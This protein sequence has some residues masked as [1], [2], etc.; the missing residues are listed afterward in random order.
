MFREDTMCISRR[1]FLRTTAAVGGSVLALQRSAH[2]AGSD[3]L[4]V[5]LVGCGSRGAGAA[6]NAI[7]ADPGVRVVA[8]ADAFADRVQGTL[9]ALKDRHPDQVD[10]APE[11]C[12]V[13]FDAYKEV[14]ACE[15]DVVLLAAPPHFRPLH[16]A[17]AI[18]AGKHVFAEKPVG[19]DATGVRSVMATC[20]RAKQKNLSVVS[21]LCWRYDTVIRETIKRVHDGAIGDIVAVQ[22]TRNLGYLWERTRQPEWTEMEFQMRNWYYFTW[23]SGDHNVE[24]QIHGLDKCTWALRDRAPVKAWATS[25]RQVRVEP[26]FGDIYDHHAVVYE[27]D[28]GARM[29]ALARQQPNCYN[30]YS[31]MLMG[32]KGRCDLQKGRIE[33]ETNWAFGQQAGDLSGF[34]VKKARKGALRPMHQVEQDEMFAAI[35]AGKTINNGDYMCQSTLIAIMGRTAGYTGQQITWEQMQ[36]SQ[37]DLSPQRYAFD[38]PPPT[39]PGPDGNYLVAMPGVTK[40]V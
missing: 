7:N 23:L 38:A 39:L 16:L 26:K 21:G 29:Y 1:Q 4:R 32:T 2:A 8:L 22:S 31:E 10:V 11:R 25:G 28:D 12:F 20:E 5:G 6:S 36:Q 14:I 15:V 37:L 19:V 17:A 30:D 40:F 18:E 34:G 27:Y 35:R 24:Q 13:G 33:G 3:I 9:K